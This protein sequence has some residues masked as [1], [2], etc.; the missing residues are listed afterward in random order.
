MHTLLTFVLSFFQVSACVCVFVIECSWV[1]ACVCVWKWEKCVYLKETVVCV[2]L[3]MRVCE[4]REREANDW[5]WWWLWVSKKGEGKSLNLSLREAFCFVWHTIAFS[6]MNENPNHSTCRTFLSLFTSV[7]NSFSILNTWTAYIFGW[8]ETLK[9][10]S[11]IFYSECKQ[12]LAGLVALVL[13][14]N[15]LVWK[16]YSYRIIHDNI[17]LVQ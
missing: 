12:E 4:E 13:L 5:N 3:W 16:N 15:I 1:C 7:N 8:S 17:D 10:I 11:V 6:P 2:C 14:I 9:N